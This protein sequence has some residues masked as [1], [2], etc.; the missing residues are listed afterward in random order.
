MK[1]KNKQTNAE[2]ETE[3]NN[4]VIIETYST[5]D[6]CEDCKAGRQNTTMSPPA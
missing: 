2:N 6:V 4:E 3:G 5:R 1:T